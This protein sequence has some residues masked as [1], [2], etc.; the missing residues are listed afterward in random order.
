MEVVPVFSWPVLDWVVRWWPLLGCVTGSDGE[1]L[2]TSACSSVAADVADDVVA[3]SGD[4]DAFVTAFEV[5]SWPLDGMVTF[6]YVGQ[7]PCAVV[8]VAPTK[9][10]YSLWG[11]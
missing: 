3:G 6:A 5:E 11:T 1:D 7:I 9:L 8:R 4:A 10:E 2:A